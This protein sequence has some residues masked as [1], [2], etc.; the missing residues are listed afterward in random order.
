[1]PY[2]IFLIRLKSC[3]EDGR[4]KLKRENILCLSLTRFGQLTAIINY[5]YLGLRFMLI[6]MLIY[7]ILYKFT[8]KS[9]IIYLI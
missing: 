4:C 1:M 2:Y 9:Q 5:H 8:L 6:L 3:F 7:G